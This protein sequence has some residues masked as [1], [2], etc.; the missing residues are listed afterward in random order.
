MHTI[1]IYNGIRICKECGESFGYELNPLETS[2]SH[3]WGETFTVKMYSHRTRFK[4]LLSRLFMNL[5][6]H[7]AKLYE[8][9]ECCKIQNIR[10][11]RF[12]LKKSPFVSKYYEYISF[13]ASFFLNFK[14]TP[15]EQEYIKIIVNYVDDISSY[16][17]TKHFPFPYHFVLLKLLK[18]S[19]IEP[20][21]NTLKCKRRLTKYENLWN[22]FIKECPPPYIKTNRLAI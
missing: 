15:L 9:L 17:K 7:P 4:K 12:C 13:F 21:I 3:P 11:I 6:P 1:I 22:E 16:G 2:R 8:Y 10:D 20:A 5:S 14:F 18:G 19:D